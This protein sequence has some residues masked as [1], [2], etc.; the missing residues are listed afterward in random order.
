M[1]TNLLRSLFAIALLGAF[2]SFAYAGPGP[3]YWQNLRNQQQFNELKAGDQIAYVCNQ[4][5]TV[6]VTTVESAAKAMELCKEGA[7]IACPSC[8]METKVVLKRQR[9]DPPLQ[10]QV[11]YV[12]DKGEDCM[13]IAKVADKK[14]TN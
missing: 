12:N 11:T 2:A 4:C 1:K 9:N 5:K 10:S 6:S 13:F 14:G 7:T 8:K 3:Q